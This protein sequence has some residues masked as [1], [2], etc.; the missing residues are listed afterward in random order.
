MCFEMLFV[1]VAS[2]LAPVVSF[3]VIQE[4]FQSFSCSKVGARCYRHHV[5][6]AFTPWVEFIDVQTVSPWTRERVRK[7]A[8]EW[9]RASER[10][11][12]ASSAKQL[13]EWV[14]V[15]LVIVQSC[16]VM[17]VVFP[18]ERCHPSYPCFHY[19]GRCPLFILVVG[20]AVLVT[21]MVV[22]VL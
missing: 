11:N 22:L 5:V 9:M 21:P 7:Q 15:V 17:V 14:N 18:F 19:W 4:P 2:V 12:E 3:F 13:N 6:A 1:P 16:P 8:S 20:D 10:S